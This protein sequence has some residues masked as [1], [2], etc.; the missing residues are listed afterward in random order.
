MVAKDGLKREAAAT[1]VQYVQSGNVVG[2]GSGSTARYAILRIGELLKTGQLWDVTGVPTSESTAELARD[3]NIPL[4]SLEDVAYIDITIDGAD[5]VDP[6]LNL[7]KGLGG[8]LLREKVVACSSSCELIVVDD[9]KMVSCLG[10]R[11]PLPVEVVPFGWKQCAASLGSLGCEPCLR[12]TDGVRFVTDEGNYILDCR[13]GCMD[14]PAMLE[15]EINTIPGVMENG[16]F[17]G[18]ADLVVVVSVD[19]LSTLTR[20]PSRWVRA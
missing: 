20:E 11:V 2:L 15:R 19:G 17:L 4:V 5:E 6:Q 18:L 1:A 12:V 9:C 7:I 13:F 3:V 16:L 10:S 8:A 14:D